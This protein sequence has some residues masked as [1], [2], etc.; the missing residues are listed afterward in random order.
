MSNLR[1]TYDITCDIL[2][3]AT[4]DIAMADDMTTQN[5]HANPNKLEGM[6]G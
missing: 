1:Q 3:T 2:M 5:H 6:L 4:Y